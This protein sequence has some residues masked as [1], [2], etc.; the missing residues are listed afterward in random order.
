MKKIFLALILVCMCVGCAETQTPVVTTTTPTTKTELVFDTAVTIAVYDNISSTVLTESF[1]IC[2]KLE[3][4]YSKTIETSEVYLLNNSN[5][6]AFSAT[7]ELIMLIT[8]SLE[9]SELTDGLFDIT[10]HSL[11]ELWDFNNIIPQLPLQEDIDNALLKVS[12]E[13][14]IID[15]NNVTLLNDAKIDLGSIAKG[16]AAD[17][18][19]AYLVS[20]G[21]E[22]ATISLGG[23]V[24]TIGKKTDTDY[25]R[26]GIRDPFLADGTSLLAVDIDDLSVVT[27][28]TYE[29]NFVYDGVLYHHILNPFTGYPAD[30]DVI[31][32]T[33]ISKESIVADLLSTACFLVGIEEANV[34]IENMED[35]EAIFITNDGKI[36]GTS[37][38]GE[39]ITAY[40]FE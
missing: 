29:R 10:T 18:V 9:F 1:D 8:K 31:S 33:I 11:S 6:Q 39:T 15:G 25:W 26:V 37:G 12:Y 16:Y 38:I 14:I 19:K 21:V 17:L 28:G 24:I 13:N 40:I 2:K 7:D 5:G 23:N 36:S 4:K 32:V 22:H 20:Q 3:E 35:T 27:S 30:S 34:I